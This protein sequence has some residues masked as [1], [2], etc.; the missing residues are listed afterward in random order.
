MFVLHIDYIAEFVDGFDVIERN[1]DFREKISI[2]TVSAHYLHTLFKLSIIDADN[3]FTVK[4]ICS[5]TAM[6]MCGE[7]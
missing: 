6:A 1:Q 7:Y 3:K 2:D 5:Y 4:V